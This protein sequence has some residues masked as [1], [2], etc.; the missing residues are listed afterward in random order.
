MHSITVQVQLPEC[1]LM[2]GW[3]IHWLV[4]DNILNIKTG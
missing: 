4:V 2:I 3:G 1:E